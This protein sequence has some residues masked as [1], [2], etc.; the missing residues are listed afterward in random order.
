MR[1]I[2]EWDRYKEVNSVCEK[3]SCKQLDLEGC[4]PE[5][6]GKI[7][8]L[9]SEL[10]KKMEIQEDDLKENKVKVA[11]IVRKVEEEKSN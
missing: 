6:V 3:I 9:K 5:L 8:F 10:L 11:D 7:C 1:E 2:N 4:R